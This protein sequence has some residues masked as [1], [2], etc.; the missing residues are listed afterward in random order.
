MNNTTSN[1]QT[2]TVKTFSRIIEESTFDFIA[3]SPSIVYNEPFCSAGVTEVIKQAID[4]E[5]TVRDKGFKLK[6]PQDVTPLSVAICISVREDVALIGAGDKSQSGQKKV[7]TAEQILKLP[8]AF[9]QSNGDNKGVW[10]IINNPLTAFGL[11]VEKYKANATEKEKKEIFTLTKSRLQR[12][13]KIVPKCVNPYFVAV[14]N[15]IWDASSRKLLPF[16]PK[17]VFTSKIHTNLNLAATNPVIQTPGKGTWDVD[18]WL[19]SLGSPSFVFSIKEVIQAACLPLAPRNKMAI[20][21]S[22]NRC[23]GKGTI[24]Q[25]IRN[26]LGEEST[27]SI[28]INEFSSRFALA[29]LPDALAIVTDENDVNSF[30]KG[31]GVLK[32]VITSDVCSI[33]R[34]GYDSY[35]YRYTGLV[36]QC[37]ND[38]I[39]TDDKSFSFMRRLHVIPFEHSFVKDGNENKLIKENFIYRTD[40]LEYILKMVLVDMAYRDSFTE[41]AETK[42]TLQS[43]ISATNNVVAFLDEVLAEAQWDLFPATD[44]LYE[45][46]KQYAKKVSPSGNLIGRNDF[47]ASIKEYVDTKTRENPNFEWEWTDSTRTDN[48][49]DFSVHEPLVENYPVEPFNRVMYQATHGYAC[50]DTDKVKD[51]YSGLKRRKAASPSQGTNN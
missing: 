43:F 9:Y 27:I 32:S 10:E 48:Y 21:Y 29:N 3:Q 23:S 38:K 11:L 20:F 16:D 24:C 40:V 46:Y 6:V 25:T 36:L 7:L 33:E 37:V 8:I 12:A 42:A 44:L 45:S 26:I 14:N 51:K 31:M 19:N 47:I 22:E 5:N 28:P 13:R 49:I 39:R 2:V 1:I 30:S 35:S 34:K 18:S 41:T 4:L 50:V 17:I 15:G